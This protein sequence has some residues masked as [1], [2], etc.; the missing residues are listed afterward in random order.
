M[1]T[2]PIF[3]VKRFLQ[4]K[5]QQDLPPQINVSRQPP[6]TMEQTPQR[7]TRKPPSF[8]SF[9]ANDKADIRRRKSCKTPGSQQLTEV[10]A[11]GLFKLTG[12]L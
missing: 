8:Q 4:Q 2:L 10:S 9:I 7:A 1:V 11:L 3:A 6:F 12:E 5:K